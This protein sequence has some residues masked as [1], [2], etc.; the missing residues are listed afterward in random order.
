[1]SNNK[2]EVKL[3]NC[4]LLDVKNNK[5]IKMKGYVKIVNY[6]NKEYF[7]GN[8]RDG[9][10]NNEK[11]ILIG[12]NEKFKIFGQEDDGSHFVI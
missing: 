8:L 6:N 5:L 9:D 12:S 2:R 4:N 3:I 11:Y 1:M 10:F 7:E